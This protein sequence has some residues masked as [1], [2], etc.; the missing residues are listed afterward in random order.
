MNDIPQRYIDIWN[1]TDPTRRRAEL[2]QLYAEDATYTDPQVEL[3]GVEEI[4]TFIAATQER[5]PGMRFALAGPVD[6]H[7]DLTRFQWQAG[8]DGA[9]E[10]LVIGFDVLVTAGERVRQVC[11]FID[12]APS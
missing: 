8:P 9:S 7:H 3:R 11:G 2:A 1:V 12:Q 5:F 6:S 10:P 4:D